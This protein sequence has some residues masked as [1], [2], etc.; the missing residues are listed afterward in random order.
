MLGA[1]R[2][3]FPSDREPA[4][5]QMDTRRNVKL[6]SRVSCGTAIIGESLADSGAEGVKFTGLLEE[7]EGP[8]VLGFDFQF[9]SGKSCEKEDVHAR[10]GFPKLLG[11]GQPALDIGKQPVGDE[12]VRREL[13]S[14]L[15]GFGSAARRFHFVPVTSQHFSENLPRNGLIFD[16]QN[17]CHASYLAAD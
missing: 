10:M 7:T 15:D 2:D 11:H 5:S 1:Q 13:D 8:K 16:D 4:N 17:F 9:V 14:D 3:S 12:N 6:C